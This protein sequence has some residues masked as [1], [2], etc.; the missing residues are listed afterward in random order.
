ME[1][2]NFNT[3]KQALSQETS[4]NFWV[5]CVDGS[6]EIGDPVSFF[7]KNV[8]DENLTFDIANNKVLAN[9]S[10]NGSIKHLSI[11]RSSYRVDCIPG[12]WV[13][14]DF[15]NTG[16]YSYSVRIGKTVHDLSKVDWS[17]KTSLLDN[18]FPVTKLTDGEKVSITLITYA[19]ISQ[20]GKIRL[21]GIIYGLYLE[22]ISG[23][24]ITG[25][26]I[27]PMVN[28]SREERRT[29]RD[30]YICAADYTEKRLEIPYNLAPGQHIWV[31]A[32][33]SAP[34][35]TVVEQID[36]K[37]S[38]Y[39][40]NSTWSYFKS[41][42]GKLS[43]PKD[44]FMEEFFQRAVHQCIE[45][46]GMDGNGRIAGSNWGTYPTTPEIWMKDMYY[47]FLPLFLLETEFF[48]EGIMWFLDYSIRP[49]GNKFNGGIG[50]SLSNA[51]TPVI[52]AGLYYSSTGDREFFLNNPEIKERIKSSLNQVIVSR[53]RPD[54]WLF[55]S[56][57][58]SD[59]LSLGD[60]HTGSNVVAWYSFK[61]FARILRDVFGE[62]ETAN[63]YNDIADKVKQDLERYCIINGPY[64]RQYI[65]G[66]N[67][68][69]S[70]PCMGHDGEE[71]D[72]TLMPLYGY[73]AYDNEVFK[74]YTQFA[75]SKYNH[76]YVPETKGLRWHT[77][78][79]TDGTFPGYIT[80]FANVINC[81][82]MNGEDGY[83]TEIRR[84]TDND[85]SLWWWPYPGNGKY[86][87]VVRNHIAGKCGWASGVFAGLFISEI[88]GIKYDG[89]TR[90]LNF[91]PFSPSSDFTWNDFRLGSSIFCAGFTR[92]KHEVSAVIEN[93]NDYSV[94][95]ELEIPLN[96]NCVL[97]ALFV[98]D[99][100]I[101][102]PYQMGEFL[103]EPTVK[104]TDTLLPRE[105]KKI[106]IIL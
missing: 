6:A 56:I 9:I 42:T 87:N 77:N 81:K 73:L 80:G 74:N 11:Y 58:I 2:I 66:V 100:E 50:H 41:I 61:S 40:L 96:G 75:V 106:R 5:K 37:G 30:V 24:D 79:S 34:G 82:S 72:T 25:S 44:K 88:L 71:S 26:I 86:G 104:L 57:W 27:L 92:S 102:G 14:K 31:P 97:K 59:G 32:V 65:E 36:E 28:G 19:P 7:S 85:G 1:I 64:G 20:D 83:M 84:L 15:S 95:I 10:L 18:I 91:R 48:K 101:K 89:S 70:V 12:V 62:H 60:Y 63:D 13:Q 69:N 22:N 49:K 53:E 38:L 90:T 39:W 35:E 29:N 52:M 4:K 16:P 45:S 78:V 47:S 21:R 55:P 98:N 17:L 105:S 76:F 54:I 99:K 33:L 103:N 51:L 68:D 8:F 67:E 43:M 3:I 46:I 93:K 94:R 23:S